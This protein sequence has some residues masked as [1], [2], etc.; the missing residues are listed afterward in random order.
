VWIFV[1]LCAGADYVVLQG[2]PS[3]SITLVLNRGKYFTAFY[4]ILS[5]SR[6]HNAK[7]PSSSPHHW[8][9]HISNYQSSEHQTTKHDE[10][11]YMNSLKNTLLSIRNRF[12]LS[13]A[14][15]GLG[16]LAALLLPLPLLACYKTPC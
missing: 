9:T 6:N 5:A 12:G 8:S 4:I 13:F 16:Y 10:R 1:F 15:K 2:P 11:D 14:S 7:Q 3:G